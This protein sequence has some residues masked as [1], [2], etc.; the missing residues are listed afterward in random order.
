MGEASP[1]L[2]IWFPSVPNEQFPH[3]SQLPLLLLRGELLPF[4]KPKTNRKIWH[5]PPNPSQ[6]LDLLKVVGFFF[7]IP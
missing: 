4:K 7:L 5:H 3:S 1:N 6:I 2:P